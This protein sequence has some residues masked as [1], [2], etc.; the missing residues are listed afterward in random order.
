MALLDADGVP[1]DLSRLR[2]RDAAPSVQ[3]V[4]RPE[5]EDPATGLT[6]SSLATL[7]RDAEDGDTSASYALAERI[8]ERDAHYVSVLRTRKLGV[9]ALAPTI[10]AAS[11]DPRDVEIADF[12]R[13]LADDDA[14][15]AALFDMLDAVGKGV[16][17]TEIVWDLDG[18]RWKP[19]A[20]EWVDPRHLGFDPDDRKTPLVRALPGEKGHG[21]PARQ[22]GRGVPGYKPLAPAK[23][24]TLAIRSKSGST[25]RSGIARVAAWYWLFKSFDLKA[26]VEFCEVYGQPLRVGKYPPN[27]TEEQKRTLL[28]AVSQIARDAGAIVPASMLLEFVEASGNRDGKLYGD[29]ATF[30]DLQMSKLVLGQTTTTDAVSGGHAVSKE[31]EKVRD[32]I[33]DADAMMLAMSVRK[34]LLAPAVALNFGPGARVPQLRFQAPEVFDPTTMSDVLVKLVP[35]GVDIEASI[36]RDKLGF[37]EPKKGAVLLRAPASAPALPPPGT[38]PP[39][40]FGATPP[41]AT[42]FEQLATAL[43]SINAG[44]KNVADAI[45]AKGDKAAEPAVRARIERMRAIV[46]SANDWDELQRDLLALASEFDPA[47]IAAAMR[48]ANLLG[49]LAGEDEVAG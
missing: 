49:R 32:D 48:D 24:L 36:V 6:P 47:E 42:P 41:G 33:R 14:F 11:D 3:G 45:A 7:L 28:R 2:E 4:R 13:E 34:C 25:P 5:S 29:L 19:K 15:R 44:A 21:E 31:H 46:A 1:I 16:S 40:P 18:P 39:P 20:Y 9:A 10:E 23:Y 35:L 17:V 8:E 37:P 26:W 43:A 30:I 27:A 12:C 38:T 22:G